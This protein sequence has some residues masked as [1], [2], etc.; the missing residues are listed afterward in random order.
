M[1]QKSPVPFIAV[2]A[3]TVTIATVTD[4]GAGINNMIALSAY[5]VDFAFSF[6]FS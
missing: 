5:K 3:D 6:Y 4:V 1:R 2:P